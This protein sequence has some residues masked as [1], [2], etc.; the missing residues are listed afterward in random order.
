MQFQIEVSDLG[1]PRKKSDRNANVV[2]TVVRNDAAPR[3]VNLPRRI[4]I[5]ENATV[6]KLILWISYICEC[7]LRKQTDVHT[8]LFGLMK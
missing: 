4:S 2:V 7:I 6:G 5:T 1:V 8:L 3:L